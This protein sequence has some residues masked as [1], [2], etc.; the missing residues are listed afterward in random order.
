MHSTR[1]RSLP[2]LRPA[3]ERNKISKAYSQ[4]KKGNFP[5]LDRGQWKSENDESWTKPAWYDIS[6]QIWQQELNIGEEL[7]YYRTQ[8]DKINK[9]GRWLSQESDREWHFDSRIPS[10]H[11][12]QQIPNLC[13]ASR[14]ISPIKWICL[15]R[16][17]KLL[18]REKRKTSKDYRLPE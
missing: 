13:F 11:W 7:E 10:N 18:F 12:K 6:F 1:F 8:K 4:I 5:S 14:P 2:W 9:P 16:R 3:L 15:P 17:S